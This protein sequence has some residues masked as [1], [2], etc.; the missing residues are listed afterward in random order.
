MEYSIVRIGGCDPGLPSRRERAFAG[1]VGACLFG[2][3]TV[4]SAAPVYIPSYHSTSASISITNPATSEL[5]TDPQ[6]VQYNYPLTGGPN[7]GYLGPVTTN[8]SGVPQVSTGV[9]ARST[10]G[11]WVKTETSYA[12][13]IL[14]GGGTSSL[15]VGTPVTLQVNL[16]V[17][18]TLGAFDGEDAAYGHMGHGV[19][20]TSPGRATYSP[21][22]GW[23]VPQVMT[24][25]ADADVSADTFFTYFYGDPGGAWYRSTSYEGGWSWSTNLGSADNTIPGEYTLTP[26]LGGAGISKTFDTGPLAIDF[27][28][29]VGDTLNFSLFFDVWGDTYGVGAQATANFL[30]TAQV[31]LSS[32]YVAGIAFTY[33]HIPAPVPIPAAVWLLGTALGSLVA[34]QRRRA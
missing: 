12:T 26:G 3:A 21:G 13:T 23:I 8:A 30:A 17:G 33:G 2:V 34:F 22:D 31:S 29:F 5:R 6:S 7:S 4:T 14:V 11:G 20:I 19:R 25:G 16:Q 32:P 9:Y 18:G 1:L 24:F 27:E 15:A 28:T 10:G